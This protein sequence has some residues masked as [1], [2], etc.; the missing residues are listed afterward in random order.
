MTNREHSSK[1]A[2]KE[3]ERVGET[4]RLRRRETEEGKWRVH[5]RKTDEDR[6]GVRDKTDNDKTVKEKNR[7]RKRRIWRKTNNEQ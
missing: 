6:E 5:R 7:R 1:K 2:M 3:R 4:K